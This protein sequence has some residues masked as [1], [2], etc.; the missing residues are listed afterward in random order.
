MLK[1]NARVHLQRYIYSLW[2]NIYI[3]I[4]KLAPVLEVIFYSDD[5][6]LERAYLSIYTDDTRNRLNKEILKYIYMC[7]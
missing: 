6:K 1:E 7:M 3:L 2:P 4:N 5:Y